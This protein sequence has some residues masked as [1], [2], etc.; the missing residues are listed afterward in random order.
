MKRKNGKG[1]YTRNIKK[2]TKTKQKITDKIPQKIKKKK[3]QN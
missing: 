1:S 2:I 3:T